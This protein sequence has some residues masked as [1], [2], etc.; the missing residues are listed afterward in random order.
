MMGRQAK[1]TQLW[2]EPVNVFAR[3]PED[4]FLRRLNTCLD[5]EF[6]RQEVAALYGRNGQ[7]SVDPVV[8]MKM[9]LLLFLDDVKSER[10]LMRIIPLRLDYLWFLGYGL[11]DKVPD[12]SVLSKA[13]QRWGQEVF[14]R[15]FTRTVE[16]CAHAGLIGGDK[17]HV[18]ASLIRADAA[19]NSVVAVEQTMAKLSEPEAVPAEETEPPEPPEPPEGGSGSV[20]ERHKVTTDPDATLV[21]HRSG[22]SLPSYKHHRALDDRAGVITAVE[23]TT[24]AVGDASQLLDLVDQHAARLGYLPRAVIG[25]SA[26]GTTANFIG[27]AQRRIRA[28][29][30]DLRSRLRNARQQGIYGEEHF[31]YDAKGD[32]FT[33][34]AGQHLRRHHFHAGRGCFEYRARPGVCAACPL[35]SACTRAKDGRSLKRYAGQEL[36][37]RAR[38]QSHGPAA[39]RDRKRRQWFQER[40]FGEAAVEHGFKRARWRGLWRQQIQDLLIAAL[41][42]LKIL[43]RR[44]ASFPGGGRKLLSVAAAI[45][46]ILLTA[47][48]Y[49]FR[50][51]QIFALTP[52]TS[53]A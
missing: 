12:H 16:Q 48:T 20:N 19:L 32:Y 50:S 35:A 47:L 1:Q 29:V 21:R 46:V 40:N 10:E 53:P 6:V 27:L 31:D 11:E 2:S 25:D 5:L 34:P 36:L 8:I 52:A 43:L 44:F 42:N 4:H 23:T 39:R 9:M 28:H 37:D 17:V 7:V 41:Q 51:L 18:D 49:R 33:C 15:L 22:K 45:S 26:Y 14:G 38:R 13:R 24:G 30:A 3:I